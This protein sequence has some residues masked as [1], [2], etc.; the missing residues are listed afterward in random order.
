MKKTSFKQIECIVIVICYNLM[1]GWCKHY[2]S[3]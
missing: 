1:F 3:V 2:V